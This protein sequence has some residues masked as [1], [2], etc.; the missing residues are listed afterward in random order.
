M[1]ILYIVDEDFAQYRKPS[2]LVAFPYCTF[3][4]G[5]ENCQNYPA[6]NLK[7]KEMSAKT[8]VERYI[9]N[10]ITKA[11]VFGGLEPLESMEDVKEL[12]VAIREVSNDTI[13][14][15]TGFNEDEEKAVE[16]ISFIKECAYLNII[17]K[18]G[19]Y[20]PSSPPKYEPRLGVKLASS[21]QYAVK[22]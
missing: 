10:P 11:I 20:L 14:I 9:K 18:F 1:K 22:Y 4:C 17:I 2:M 15:Y 7:P 5:K 12:I 13:V 21:N 3:K 8:I 16:I 6:R 19:R